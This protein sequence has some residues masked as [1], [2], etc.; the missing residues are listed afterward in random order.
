MAFE[1]KF[2]V[3]QVKIEILIQKDAVIY[4]TNGTFY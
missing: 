1:K 2:E 4:E 3:L